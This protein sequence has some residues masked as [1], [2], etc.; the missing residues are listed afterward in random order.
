M[1]DSP[2]PRRASYVLTALLVAVGVI[3]LLVVWYQ[4]EIAAPLF[5]KRFDEYGMQLPAATKL[6]VRLGML[7]DGWLAV[8]LVFGAMLTWAGAIGW[9]R[10]RARWAAIVTVYV[11]LVIA[12]LVVLNLIVAGP[13]ILAEM[14]LQEGL[15][16]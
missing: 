12:A 1:P 8:L 13:L 15:A 16:R 7:V 6:V 10:H 2:Q 5:K 4:F 3:L 14:K 9:L 11:W